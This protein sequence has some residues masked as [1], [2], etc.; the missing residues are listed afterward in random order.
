MDVESFGITQV[1]VANA[2]IDW[3]LLKIEGLIVWG[4]KAANMEFPL[5]L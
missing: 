3:G 5:F 4:S 2:G 1:E